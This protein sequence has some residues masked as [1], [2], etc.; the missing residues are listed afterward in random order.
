MANENN[1][2]IVASTRIPYALLNEE[3]DGSSR[4]IQDEFR[5][6]LDYYKVF[7][8]GKDF[9]VEGTNGDYIPAT[10]KYKTT[11]D[12][13]RKEARFLFAEA[14]DII[15]D[16]KGDAGLVTDDIKENLTNMQNIIDEVLEKNMFEDILLKAARDCFIGK[17]VA[18]LV[19]F[20]EES[21]VTI[22]F[23]SSLDFVYETALDNPNKITK[24]VAFIIVKNRTN[25][26]EKRIFKK[27]FELVNENGKDVCYLEENL[28][29]GA[30]TL[31]EEITPYQATKLDRIP[32]AV[33]INDGLTND[34]YGESEVEWLQ[35]HEEWY[36]KLCNADKDAARKSMNPIRYT[37]DM[38]A[39]STQSLS[40]APGS[41]W[42]LVSD[43]NLEKSSPSV[44]QLTSSLEYS[45]AL[46][47]TLKRIKDSA[48]DKVDMPDIEG[49]QAQLAS[50]KALKAIYWPLIVRCKEK[51][52]TWGPKLQY[53]V[54]CIIQG[55]FVYP[56]C[57]ERYTNYQI[58]PCDYE[59][60]VEQ[61]FPLPEDETE[62]KA[63]DLAEVAA[64]TMSKKAYMK[65][66]R[67]LT[68][69]EAMEELEQMALE[70]QLLEE[71][72]SGELDNSSEETDETGLSSDVSE[73]SEEIESEEMGNEYTT[74][75]DDVGVESE[76]ESEEITAE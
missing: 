72:F 9:T 31:I 12:L 26:K 48:Y 23:L 37:I 11:A 42:D 36:S 15:V 76:E 43:Q 54:D 47:T 70:R 30:G 34:E 52:K 56:N 3:I 35:D 61:N 29:D 1:T 71:S 41:Y 59:I 58:V 73:G 45:Q 67:N 10:L 32:V 74:T 65:K 63:N 68:D 40:T 50:G 21:G 28:Y 22:S 24:F 46:E 44:G 4:D 13:I 51:M 8:K 2:S 55:A 14:P 62:E 69:Q 38:E 27:K 5:Q 19:N 64:Q 57:F 39:S 33:I 20:N 16:S 60:H 53:I 25:L 17:R 7:N 18:C 49:I 6:I 66:W 75:V